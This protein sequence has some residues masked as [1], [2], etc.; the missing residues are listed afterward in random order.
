MS[1]ITAKQIKKFLEAKRAV[2]G[3]TTTL[4]TSNTITTQL[5]SLASSNGVPA[6]VANKV[7]ETVGFIISGNNKAEIWLASSKDAIQDGKGNEVYGKITKPG[8]DYLI[9]FY[10]LING[11][12]TAYSMPAGRIIDFTVNY[13]FDF[14][15]LPDDILTKISAIEVGEDPDSK[16]GEYI[17]LLTVT[18]INTVSDLTK[19][20]ISNSEPMQLIIN[21]QV[22]DNLVNGAF[23]INGKAVTWSFTNSGYNL[24][25]TDR[26][27]AKYKTFE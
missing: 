18:A 13:Y 19:S 10:S 21:G 25:T 12:E 2:T 27:V 22:E 15:R 26:V 5:G 4:G 8:A 20:P 14:G 1:F 24:E 11:V 6:Q 23:F 9:E 16:A 17:E 7:T 3:F